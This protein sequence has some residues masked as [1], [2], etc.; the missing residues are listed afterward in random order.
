MNHHK[1]TEDT[2]IDGEDMYNN[3]YSHI[4]NY[5]DSNRIVGFC[6]AQLAQSKLE[7]HLRRYLINILYEVER[8]FNMA[9]VG[10]GSWDRPVSTDFMLHFLCRIHIHSPHK[11]GTYMPN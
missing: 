3:T 1:D 11:K 10:C 8:L 6:L 4:C 2:H 7:D 9:I 5:H